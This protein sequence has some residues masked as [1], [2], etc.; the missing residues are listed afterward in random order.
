[1]LQAFVATAPAVAPI[2]AAAAAPARVAAQARAYPPAETDALLRESI[3]EVLDL[4]EPGAIGANE[5][6]HA[7]GMDSITLVELRDQLVRRL[8]RELP[9]RLLFDFPQVGQL[10][11]YLALGQPEAR[12]AQP[13]PATH[14]AA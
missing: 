1:M 13:A 4:P 8:G 10:A 5:T 3:A 11:R 12:R 14:G 2:A 6:L 9:S 7:L